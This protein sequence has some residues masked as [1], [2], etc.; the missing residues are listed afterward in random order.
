MHSI[1]ILGRD[2]EFL[3]TS[4]QESRGGRL[5]G[6]SFA[7][8]R[9][10]HWTRRISARADVLMVDLASI[11]KGIDLSQLIGN[12]QGHALARIIIV[13]RQDL[14]D[15]DLTSGPDE[16]LVRTAHPEEV[17]ARVRHAL[18]RTARV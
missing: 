6:Y 5:H 10:G 7:R 14:A 1:V 12:V 16:F 11:G 13:P 9:L 2:E 4:C 8:L 18:W 3:A 15:L 17:T